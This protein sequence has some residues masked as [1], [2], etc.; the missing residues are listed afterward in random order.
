MPNH[1]LTELKI[2][3]KNK[4]E[5]DYLINILTKDDHETIDFNKIIPEPTSIE[6]CPEKY[7]V[8]EHSLISIEKDRPWFNWYTW[9]NKYWGTKWDAYDGTVYCL[10]DGV[11]FTF[12]TAW[13]PAMPIFEKLTLL[14]LDFEIKYADEDIGSNCG[15]IEYYAESNLWCDEDA[16]ELDDPEAFAKELWGYAEDE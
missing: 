1:I 7:R 2:K 4:S 8:T 9:H 5:Q 10:S 16:Y 3:T 6:E 12:S 14:G 13:S 11:L 15:H